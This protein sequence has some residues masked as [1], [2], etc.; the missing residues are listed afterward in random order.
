MYLISSSS[1]IPK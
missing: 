1:R